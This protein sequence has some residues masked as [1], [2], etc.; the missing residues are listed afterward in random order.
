MPLPPCFTPAAPS[1]FE[2]RLD[3]FL[4]ILN[5]AVTGLRRHK[6]NPP[7]THRLYRIW[8]ALSDASPAGLHATVM[9]APLF[10]IFLQPAAGNYHVWHIEGG[11]LTA[12]C[13]RLWPKLFD[14]QFLKKSNCQTGPPEII[15]QRRM[16]TEILNG[17]RKHELLCIASIK[18]QFSRDLEWW[19]VLHPTYRPLEELHVSL[20]HEPHI[21]RGTRIR[22]ICQYIITL[23]TFYVQSNPELKYERGTLIAREL[24]EPFYFFQ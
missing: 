23:N 20:Y 8:D 17:Q 11:N 10:E 1:M 9:K 4:H 22:M 18:W 16:R 19:Q 6:R 21:L 3:Q 2:K 12:A 7:P 13:S 14:T 15:I 24:R 5:S